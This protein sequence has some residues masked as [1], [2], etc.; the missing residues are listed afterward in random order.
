[1]NFQ[2]L[3]L[4][5]FD[6]W[7]LCEKLMISPQRYFLRH[8]WSL[9]KTLVSFAALCHATLLHVCVESHW[10]LFTLAHL[11]GLVPFK[12]LFCHLAHTRIMQ[13]DSHFAL[14]DFVCIILHMHFIVCKYIPRHHNIAYFD[15]V[16]LPFITSS[17]EVGPTTFSHPRTLSFVKW[18]VVD[19]G[20]ARLNDQL[21][22]HA[23][24]L[25]FRACCVVAPNQTPSEFMAEA[26]HWNGR[27]DII[28]S[29]AIFYFPLPG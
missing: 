18:K 17:A 21:Q 29:V 2:K 7:K 20:T 4:S 12:F 27:V 8:F 23:C 28:I 25:L 26:K 13:V 5:Q 19:I 16:T 24:C 14:V 3:S 1:M 11:P 15:I 10:W 6:M 9:K 22:P